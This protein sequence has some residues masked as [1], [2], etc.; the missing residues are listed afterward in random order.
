MLDSCKSNIYA[1]IILLNVFA[2]LLLYHKPLNQLC[3]VEKIQIHIQKIYNNSSIYLI[4]CTLAYTFNDAGQVIMFQVIIGILPFPLGCENP[5][6]LKN[7]KV[8]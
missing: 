8:M 6:I 5:L 7:S 2:S 1:S 3:I 4:A